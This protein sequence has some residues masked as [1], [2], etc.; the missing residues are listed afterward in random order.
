MGIYYQSTSI[1]DV[2]ARHVSALRGYGAPLLR[3]TLEWSIHPKRDK[4]YA[5]FGTYIRVSATVEGDADFIHLGHALSE[6][7]WT[8][9]ARVGIPYNSQVLYNLTLSADQLLAIEH[10]RQNRGLVFTLEVRG[11]AYGETGICS[12]DQ[13]LTIAIGLG[14]WIKVLSS[15]GAD[16]SLLV[17]LPMPMLEH[18]VPVE[19]PAVLVRNA[20]KYLQNG[21]YD[22]CIAECRRAMESLWKIANVEEPARNARKALAN[23]NDRR[24]MSKHDR[25]LALGEALIAL[26][27]TAHHVGDDGDPEVFSRQD[28]T[29]TLAT[30][31]ALVGTLIAPRPM[32]EPEDEPP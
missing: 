19:T 16:D 30:A 20:H 12:I 29:L 24:A 5:I 3:F 31:S 10:R 18:S 22:A 26:T 14:D 4:D 7:A 15:A 23:P 32:P 2:R 21:Q 6:V 11:N 25:I 8:E 1:G 27:H 9:Q 17:G 13:T 28:A